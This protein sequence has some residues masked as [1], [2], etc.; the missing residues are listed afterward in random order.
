MKIK[1]PYVTDVFLEEYKKYFS[2]N[3]LKYYERGDI[4]TIK[5]IFRNRDNVRISDFEFEYIPL[6]VKNDVD[7]PYISKINVRTLWKSLNK[8]PPVQAE[9]EKIWVALENTIYLDYH[10]A[11]IR[12]IK[13]IRSIESKTIF[14]NGQKRSLFI[15]SLASLWWLGYY[16]IDKNSENP[17]WLVDFFLDTPYRGNEVVLFSSNIVSRKDTAL[18]ILEGIKELKE[19]CNLKI[20][21]AAYSNSCKL[22]NQI[23]GVRLL[24]TLSRKEIKEIIVNNLMYM[25][26]SIKSSE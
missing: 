24:D 1:L 10:M 21:R 6:K 20:N 26:G 15:N 16:L 4:D 8:L 18:G 7:D 12:N 13:N 11:S 25:K 14:N 23:G 17:F 22:L 3:Y 2:I 9:L 19:S 5:S